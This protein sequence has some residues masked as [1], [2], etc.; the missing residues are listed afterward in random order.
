MAELL[1]RVQDVKVASPS[2]MDMAPPVSALFLWRA[3]D[4]KIAFDSPYPLGRGL[5]LA[6]FKAPPS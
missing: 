1:W 3:Q 4:V 5:A 2:T 6:I